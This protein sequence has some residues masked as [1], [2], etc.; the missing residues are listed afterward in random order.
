MSRIRFKD[1]RFQRRSLELLGWCEGVIQRYQEQG[2]KLTLR[3]LYYQLVVQNV[4]GNREQEYKNLGNL[5]SRGRLAGVLD[6]NAIEDRIR[7]PTTPLDFSG[8]SGLI[9]SAIHWYKLDRW[10]NQDEYV[11]LWVEKDA[12]A[13]VLAPIAEERH[14]TLMVNRGYSSQSAMYDAS[15]RFFMYS[16][17]GRT[18]T[19]LY[20]GDLDPSGEDMVRDIDERLNLVFGSPVNVVKVAITPEQVEEYN[21][22]PNPAKMTDSRAARYVMEHGYESFEVDALPPEVL[23]TLINDAVD[24]HVDKAMFDEVLDQEETDKERLE[25]IALDLEG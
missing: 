15:N 22:P 23:R 4:I 3:Q 11:E 24:R 17:Q 19:I 1:Y 18:C 6:W 9:R 7:Q 12:L 20:L 8:P 10:A 5:V 2:L 21:P 14:I 13:G 16:D 25:E